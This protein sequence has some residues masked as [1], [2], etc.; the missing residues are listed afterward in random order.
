MSMKFGTI[1]DY[2]YNRNQ[3]VKL[4]ILSMGFLTGDKEGHTFRIAVVDRQGPVDLTGASVTGWFIPNDQGLVDDQSVP[5]KGSVEG[6][7]AILSLPPEAYLEEGRFRLVIKLNHDGRISTIFWGAGSV[8]RSNTDVYVDVG[9]VIPSLEEWLAQIEKME[10]ATKETK[11][12]TYAANAATDR[13]NAA[14][15]SVDEL[16]ADAEQAIDEAQT[17]VKKAGEITASWENATAQ[18]NTV[19]YD[20]PA[21]AEL[22]MDENG[23][24]L[25]MF[26]IPRGAPGEEG[27]TPQ[28]GVD[29]FD[30]YT[31]QKGIDYFDGYTPQKGI[32]YFD[33]KPGEPG[34][35]FTILGVYDTYDDLVMSVT[36]PAQGDH[37]DVGTEEPYTMYMW[38][39]KS[40]WIN[41][42]SLNAS[43]GASLP[44]GGTT[45]QIL[46]KNSSNDGDA[47]WQNP[48]IS[49]PSGGV[50]GQVLTKN[51]TD[52]GDAVWENIPNE[53]PSNG[54]GGQVLYKT[55]SGGVEW[56][57]LPEQ[58]KE[59]PVDGVNGQVLYKTTDGVEWKNLPEQEDELPEG[60]T[61]GQILARTASG[62]VEWV[63]PLAVD[64]TL[65][66]AGKA[67]DAGAVG[68]ALN[69]LKNEIDDLL[70]DVTAADVGKFLR[71]SSTGAWAAETVTSAEG[72]SF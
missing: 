26:D 48:P 19:D 51:G 7:V 45:G 10:E 55:A 2:T 12:A 57:S 27:Y 46:T 38:D 54:T 33:G 43:S 40:G 70:P 69:E 58:E 47:S 8:S 21:S 44:E 42:G 41:K 30:G 62:G 4:T 64:D 13:A 63:T 11:D 34:K 6:N 66:E 1:L 32:D 18:A 15:D 56:N 14:A 59:L 49:L 31:P 5:L 37:Y 25:L 72:V 3:G 50:K 65:K 23:N 36:N 52:D 29:Y 61:T 71:V 35:N 20:V 39:D 16:K 60:G 9:D 67:A 22:S 17:A 24:R 68:T 28:K 53:L